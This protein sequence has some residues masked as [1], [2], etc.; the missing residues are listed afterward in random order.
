MPP[1][2]LH[3]NVLREIAEGTPYATLDVFGPTLEFVSGPDD[4]AAG[5][6]VM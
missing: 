3:S 5:F 6:C 1:R 4:P 2:Q